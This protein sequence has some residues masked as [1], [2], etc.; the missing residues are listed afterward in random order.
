MKTLRLVALDA[1]LRLE[2]EDVDVANLL[3]TILRDLV[4]DHVP[5]TDDCVVSVAGTGPWL[6]TGISRS[7][8]HTTLPATL[9][10]TLAMVNHAALAHT[11]LLTFHAA[12]VTRRDSTLVIPGRST[13]GKSTLTACLLRHGWR[14]VSDE[15]LAL[16]WTTGTLVSYPRPM[17]LS[18]W[19]C[20][21]AGGIP[22]VFADGEYIVRAVDAGADVDCAPGPVRYVVLLSRTDGA[23]APRLVPVDRNEALAELLQRGFTFNMNPSRAL[24]LV[25]ELLRRSVSLRL[26]LGD[27]LVAAQAI[28]VATD[29]S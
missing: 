9:T 24:V 18:P 22:G 29:A 21:A 20:A 3:M 23:Q 17:S 16:H 25:T 14:Y 5:H 26:R 12:V 7:D 1:R 10:G 8:R 27:P 11:P 6:V 28:T 13:S 19:S 2:V 4:S 15:A